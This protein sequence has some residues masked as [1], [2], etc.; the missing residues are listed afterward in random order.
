MALVGFNFGVEAGQLAVIATA[1]LL[2]FRI[3]DE[4][5]R[6]KF[7]VIPASAL[8]ALAGLWWVY[9]RVLG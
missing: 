8:I 4:Q 1:W 9:E 6:R 5:V 2:T 3:T 7:V